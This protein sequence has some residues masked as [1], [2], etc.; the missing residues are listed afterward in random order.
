[1]PYQTGTASSFSNLQ[2]TI[3]TFLTGTPGYTLTS[4]ILT[5]TGTDAHL[6]FANATD[7]ISLEMG[8]DSSAGSLLLKHPTME[9]GSVQRVGMVTG[10]WDSAVSIVFPINYYLHY[11]STP[12]EMFRCIIEYNNGYTQNIGFGEIEKAV[13]MFG[14]F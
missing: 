3:E 5:K 2:S 6:K 8:K 13:D 11:L 7:Y 1:M 12:Q 14:G 10:Y 9:S 4:G